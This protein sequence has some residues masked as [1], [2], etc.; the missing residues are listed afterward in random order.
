MVVVL[1]ALKPHRHGEH[2]PSCASR[3]LAANRSDARLTLF[4]GDAA[5]PG[6]VVFAA[7]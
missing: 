1:A 2:T 7:L 3:G 5:F 6:Q 4:T